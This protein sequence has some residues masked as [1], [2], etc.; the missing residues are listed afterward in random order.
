MADLRID[1]DKDIRIKNNKDRDRVYTM[2]SGE[3]K[4]MF[5]AIQDNIFTFCEATAG[6]GKTLV[7]VASMLD[8][9]ANGEING[10]IYI[11]KVSQRFL[12]NGF[13]PG[14]MEEKTNALWLP[15]LDAMA[16]LGY[17]P[18]AVFKMV[19]N[20]VIILTTDS[21]LRGVNFEKMGIILDECSNMDEETLRLILTRCHDDCHIV[22]IGDRKQKDNRG[23]NDA[24]LAYGQYLA[25]KD[26]GCS[27]QLTHNYRGKFSQAAESFVSGDDKNCGKR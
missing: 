4:T 7:S 24:F 18:E 21:N 3:Q 23:R 5:H 11:Q 26:F 19:A 10:I 6:S 14:T 17:Q 25:D 1:S 22:M 13:L 27:V 20:G 2:F 9:Y 15:F 16:T 12:Q 8:L